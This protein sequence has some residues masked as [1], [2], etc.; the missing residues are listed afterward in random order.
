MDKA[1]GALDV[2]LDNLGGLSDGDDPVNFAYFHAKS[3]SVNSG[4]G[5]STQADNLK[6][7]N[8]F[9]V[10][11]RKWY[12]KIILMEVDESQRTFLPPRVPG[13]T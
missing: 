10:S 2:C 9:S 8:T 12:R 7:S 4:E 1:V 3:L 5:V 13:D 11:C 6:Y